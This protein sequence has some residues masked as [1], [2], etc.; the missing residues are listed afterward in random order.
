MDGA[1]C[2]TYAFPCACEDCCL[3]TVA[4][5]PGRGVRAL[6]APDRQPAH[7]RGE[8]RRA[9]RFKVVPYPMA[10]GCSAT[11]FPEANVLVRSVAQGSNQP[12][13]KSIVVTLEPSLEH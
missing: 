13:S 10:L 12:V 8:Q 5:T 3:Q 1:Q 9:D 4:Q 11:Y 7:H 6:N 2:K